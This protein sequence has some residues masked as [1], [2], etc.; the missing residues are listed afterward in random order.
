MIEEKKREGGQRGRGGGQVVLRRSR[1]EKKASIKRG[2]C[3]KERRKEGIWK[4][5][6]NRYQE[7]C[8]CGK[9][10]RDQLSGEVD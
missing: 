3:M 9:V 5:N 2:I 4:G 10:F 1:G 6:V 7:M 8:L